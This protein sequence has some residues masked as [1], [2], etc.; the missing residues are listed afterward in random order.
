LTVRVL[1]VPLFSTL[2]YLP[3]D[4]AFIE[5]IAFRVRKISQRRA[6]YQFQS[7]ATPICSIRCY[8]LDHNHRHLVEVYM[9]FRLVFFVYISCVLQLQGVVLSRSSIWTSDFHRGGRLIRRGSLLSA[10]TA[11]AH[12]AENAAVFICTVAS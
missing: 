3:R 12:E 11:Q 7:Y 4:V 6:E 10:L 8:N 1:P 5:F 9:T 2:N